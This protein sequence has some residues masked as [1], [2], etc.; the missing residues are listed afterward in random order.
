[1]DV[2]TNNPNIRP[3]TPLPAPIPITAQEVKLGGGIFDRVN[4]SHWVLLLTGSRL[5]AQMPQQVVRDLAASK[6][7]EIVDRVIKV[8]WP[9]K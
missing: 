8:D 9:K 2:Y 4:K 6:L 7:Q 5:I 3:L 1:M